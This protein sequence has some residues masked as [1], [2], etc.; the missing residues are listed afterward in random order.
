LWLNNV[1]LAIE[2]VKL[3]VQDG[4]HNIETSAVVYESLTSNGSANKAIENLAVHSVGQVVDKLI[5]KA[6]LGGVEKKSTR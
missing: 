3:R 6:W 4:G 5:D 1:D 2:R